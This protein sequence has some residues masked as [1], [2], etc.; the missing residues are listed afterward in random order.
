MRKVSVILPVEEQRQGLYDIVQALLEQTLDC[1]IL[2]VQRCGHGETGEVAADC[3]A[4]FPEDIRTVACQGSLG[5][6]WNEGLKLAQGEYVCFLTCGDKADAAMLQALYDAAGGADLCSADYEENGQRRRVAGGKLETMEE[7]AAF[8]SAP[9]CVS[10]RI[11]KRAFLEKNGLQFPEE[12]AFCH[13]AF[14]FLAALQA[15]SAAKA[16]GCY[17]TYEPALPGRNDERWYDRLL[18]PEQIAQG[19]GDA[20]PAL[21]EHKYM[22][23]QMGNIRNVCLA[24]FDRPSLSRLRSIQLQVLERYPD[25][26]E[27]KFYPRTLWE[28][29]YYLEKTV[30]SPEKAI[31]AYR[32]DA[33]V[34]LRAAIRERMGKA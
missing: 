34:Q 28:M 31:K 25:F 10:C 12:G 19:A 11:Y 22:A 9:G 27:G 16:E 18:V 5:K 33:V 4:Q 6:A 14:D 1:Q 26:R 24:M 13:L 15:G 29:R 32:W 17:L 30:Q 23:L 20:M 8:I 7:K 3:A 2:L 21:V